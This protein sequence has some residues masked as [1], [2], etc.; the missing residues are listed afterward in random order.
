M[1]ESTCEWYDPVCG[2][3]ALL[4]GLGQL[5][6]SFWNYL[7]S[8]LSSLFELIPAPAFLS[9]LATTDI[10]SGVAWAADIFQIEFGL[11]VIV[12]A[13]TLRFII[14]RIPGIG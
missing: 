5:V 2:I 6:V 12:S 11:S 9:N 10:P 7:L 4:E 8:G 14:R 3:T 13:Y 1:S